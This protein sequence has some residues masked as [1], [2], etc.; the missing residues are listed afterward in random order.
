MTD[1]TDRLQT[2]E[3][4]LLDLMRLQNRRPRC[5]CGGIIWASNCTCGS[6]GKVSIIPDDGECL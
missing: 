4:M 2:R 6:C 5:E 1:A 3:T